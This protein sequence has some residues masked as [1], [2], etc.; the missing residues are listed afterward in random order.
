MIKDIRYSGYAANPSDYDC[1]DGQLAQLLD[2]APDN[3]H[4]APPP[5]P[6]PI[7]QLSEGYSVLKMHHVASQSNYIIIK[8]G[9]PIFI[10]K[11]LKADE[12]A[13]ADGLPTDSSATTLING[14]PMFHSI[15]IV[16][17]TLVISYSDRVRYYLWQNDSYIDL[18]SAI[19]RINLEFGLRSVYNGLS[20]TVNIGDIP[21]S[22][23][24]TVE[25]LFNSGSGAS[26]QTHGRNLST[27][28]NEK[29]S[30]ALFGGFLRL[31]GSYCLKNNYFYQPF[32]VR[33]ALRMYDG[34][35]ISLSP[36]ILLCPYSG[37]P[38]F[39]I[40]SGSF[41]GDNF[42][43]SAKTSTPFCELRYRALVTNA[44]IEK[45]Q[46]WKDIIT[47]IDFFIS[48]P[49][50]TYKQSED[51]FSGVN[52]VDSIQNPISHRSTAYDLSDEKEAAVVGDSGK[53][54]VY[55]PM[56]SKNEIY[57]ELQSTANFYKVAEIKLPDRLIS[58]DTTGTSGL[59]PGAATPSQSPAGS[60]VPVPMTADDILQSLTSRER[61][62]DTAIHHS[63][64]A[65]AMFTYNSR[66]N[67]GG[68]SLTLFDGYPIRSMVQHSHLSSTDY[69]HTAIKVLVRKNGVD[70][71][72]TLARIPNSDPLMSPS[73]I[74]QLSAQFP[75]FLYYP[76]PDAYQLQISCIYADTSKNGVFSVPLT[77]HPTLNGAYY[78]RG[79]ESTD[80]T[81]PFETGATLSTAGQ[82]AIFSADNK[83][84][85]SMPNNP[86]L[87]TTKN[88]VQIGTGEIIGFSTAAKALSQGQ[89][90][91]FPLYA[92]C[93]DGIWALEIAADGTFIARQ[94]ISRDV[95]VNPDGIT[96]IDSAVLFPTDRG[97][98]LISG[99]EVICVSD[100]INTSTPFNINSLPFLYGIVESFDSVIAQ[101]TA[102]WPFNEFLSKCRMLYDYTHQRVI[103]YRGDCRYAYCYYLK[104]RLWGLLY[105]DIT[106]SID[107]YPKA[108]AMDSANRVM[109][110]SKKNGVIPHGLLL[111]RPLKL[112]HPDALK[113]IDTVI[114]RGDFPKG[115]VGCALYASRDLRDWHLVWSSKD[116]YMR[117]FSGTPYKYYRVAALTNLSEGDSLSGMTVQFNPRLLNQPR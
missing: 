44:D 108:L 8:G 23:R 26:S 32:F 82:I 55:A 13:N 63:I 37:T 3:G 20:F 16:G 107:S 114:L 9:S 76:D 49:I 60:F 106:N 100:A 19:P 50:Y 36:P 5:Q 98:M 34:A 101:A 4:I 35:H 62:S 38:R 45:I 70:Y 18:G 67:L 66:L 115:A 31:V 113:T 52:T 116:H 61:L 97:V 99:S 112:D 47:H 12:P 6:T 85:S 15:E 95:C 75:R 33:Y 28:T 57:D 109:D 40:Q 24:N 64:A 48:A 117:G 46:R 43:S 94:P 110:Y 78:F 39:E 22:D 2:L 104:S 56:R 77:R 91:Q 73:T 69:C 71:S 58:D 59:R 42:K 72:V 27:E 105:S 92:F 74:K 1:P 89:F 84:Y 111:T 65:R 81:P 83:V 11:W 29:I 88:V 25:N 17:N 30:N 86:F 53:N 90:G 7:L 41:D 51:F 14:A 102:I 80:S 68:C 87:F 54:L 96:Q 79:L 103:V 93:T 21:T 10:I